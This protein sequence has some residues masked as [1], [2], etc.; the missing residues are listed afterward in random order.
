MTRVLKVA[1]E[2]SSH[3]MYACLMYRRVQSVLTKTALE[4]LLFQS[5]LNAYPTGM[6]QTFGTGM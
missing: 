1:R 2:T 3:A 4:C 5:A 6:L